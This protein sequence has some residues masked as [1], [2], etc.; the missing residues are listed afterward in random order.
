MVIMSHSDIIEYIELLS[1][2]EKA[3]LALFACS[4]ALSLNDQVAREVIG[5]VTKSNGSTE[6]L[7]RRIKSLGCVW[8]QWDGTWYIGENIRPHLFEYLSKDVPAETHIL[9]RRRLSQL[10]E[11]QAQTYCVDGQITAFRKHRAA[12]EAAYQ[13][14]LIPG[15]TDKGAEKLAELWQESS[16]SVAQATAEAV[17][18]IAPEIDRQLKFLPLEVLF[19]RGMAARARQDKEAQLRYFREVWEKGR[20]GKIFGIGATHPSPSSTARSPGS[21]VIVTPSCIGPSCRRGSVSAA[22]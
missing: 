22:V 11:D 18:Y 5:I 20:P 16:F 10:S 12:F 2:D 7:L 9:L 19:L 4:A 6:S 17:D 15:E 14:T 3:K 21:E 1:G 8:K 13:L